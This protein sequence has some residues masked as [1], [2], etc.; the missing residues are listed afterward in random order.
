MKFPNKN[1]IEIKGFLEGY[2]SE[3]LNCFQSIDIESL[4]KIANLLDQTI[5]DGNTIFSCGNG[6]SSAISEHFVC[7]F[8]KGASTNT[9]IQPLIHSLTSNTPT[10]TAVANDIS[11]D[12]IFSFQLKKYANE[13]DILICV[14]SSGNSPNIVKSI[15]A[16]KEI[17]MRSI[18]FVGFD[19]GIAKQIS[20]YCLHI[21]NQNY[22]IVEDLHQSLMHLLA[23]YIRLK[24]LKNF[25]N[26]DSIVF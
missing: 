22:G 13:N 26:I 17:G 19:G 10:L 18:S 21:D 14:S 15:E 11:Y 2:S 7:D 6:G 1:H 16:S 5:K 9:N 24:N 4:Q 3:I 8:L 20:D 23:Q 12:D 25:E